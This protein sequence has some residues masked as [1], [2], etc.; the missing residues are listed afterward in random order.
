MP[1]IPQLPSTA[2]MM[3]LNGN[4]AFL[5]VVTKNTSDKKGVEIK[6]VV[7]NSAAAAADLQQGD[8]LLSVNDM[9]VESTNNLIEILS[10]YQPGESVS[11]TYLRN[12]KRNT[13]TAELKENENYFESEEW[14]VYGSKWEEWGESFGAQMEEWGA[15]M[16]NH[17]NKEMIIEEKA[18]LGVFL[19]A[20]D[21]GVL[22]TGISENSAAEAAGLKKGDIITSIDGTNMSSHKQVAEYIQSKQSGDVVTIGILRDE[23]PMN[24]DATL[25][26]HQTEMIFWKDEEGSMPNHFQF[27]GPKSDCNSY[28]YEF[29]DGG[30]KEIIMEIEVIEEEAFRETPE[31]EAFKASDVEFFPNPSSGTFSLRFNADEPEDVLINIRDINGALVYDE[32]LKGFSGVYDKSINLGDEAKGNYFINIVKGDYIVTKQIVI[33]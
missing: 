25:K 22:I 10:D 8:I 14:E 32:E 1:D 9:T 12:G 28:T 5:G 17:F 31:G 4:R 16:E 26:S 15:Q 19:D 2:N 29:K 13:T 23:K 24:I 11:V 21:D 6:E 18:F 27:F 20:D 33:Q 7:E 30:Q 3:F